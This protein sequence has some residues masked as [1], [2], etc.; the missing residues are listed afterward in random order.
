[1]VAGADEAVAAAESLGEPV[2]LKA[3][4]VSHK[5]EHG[6]VKLNLRGSDAVRAAARPLL[7]APRNSDTL[8][9]EPADAATGLLV[10]RHEAGAVVELIVGLHRDPLF[11]PMLTVG[12]GGTLVELITDSVTLLLPVSQAEVRTALASLGCAPMLAG[13][14]GGPPADLDAAVDAILAVAQFGVDNAERLEELDVN[15]LAV[16]TRGR[17]A[18]ALDAL[19]RIRTADAAC[20]T[21]RA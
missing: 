16:R 3:L 8:A 19:I 9:G 4:G 17:G 21:R 10:E 20:D 2:A 14:R 7:D 18:V 15:P 6:A 11:G 5:T 1:M 13:Y 12:S